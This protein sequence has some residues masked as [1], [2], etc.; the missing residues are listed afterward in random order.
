MC[1]GTK[2]WLKGLFDRAGGDRHYYH[3]AGHQTLHQNPH[4][5]IGAM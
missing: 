4:L 3:A 1:S 5:R 2:H